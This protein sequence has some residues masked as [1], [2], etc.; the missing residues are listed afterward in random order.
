MVNSSKYVTQSDRCFNFSA[1]PSA[2][3]E[4]VL[5]RIHGELFNWRNQGASIMEISHRSEAFLEIAYQSEQDLKALMNIPNNYKVL[6]LAGGARG[7]FAAVPLNLKA[8]KTQA[9][10]IDSG[11]WAHSAINE[12]QR[13]LNVNVVADN[14]SKEHPVEEPEKWR[15]SSDAAYLHYTTNETIEGRQFSFIPDSPEIPLVADMS[16]DILSAPIDVEKFG[17]IYAGAQKN[18]GP[19][20]LTIVIVR[21]DL[22]Q[23]ADKLCPSIIN[24]QTQTNFKSMY[25]TPPVFCWYVAG[26]VFQWLKEQG[27]LDEMAVRCA[28]KSSKLYEFIDNSM[29]YHNDVALSWR[30]KI[31]IP[32]SLIDASLNSVFIK[33]AEE[34]RLCYLRGHKAVGGMR[35]SLYNGVPESHVDNLI[36]FMKEFERQ[37]G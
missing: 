28:R 21:E 14:A 29:F 6:F 17:L 24:Y 20:G 16:S 25:N 34:N 2:I 5:D 33:V 1:G 15:N 13:Y 9:D 31:N 30:S 7:Q 10:Y 23:H 22:L 4:K 32:F 36:V 37:Y 35:A 8:D 12:A 11:Y 26:L 27:G 18:I 19:A 3:P